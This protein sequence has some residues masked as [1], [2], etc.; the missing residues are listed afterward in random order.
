M[1]F[2]TC[3]PLEVASR[4]TLCQLPLWR[5]VEAQ[6]VV[7]TRTLVDTQQEQELLE[8]LLERDKPRVPAAAA[9]LDYLLS[10]PF[11]YPP[12]REGSRF[13]GYTDAGVWYGAERVR[14]ACA[15]LGY[16]RWRFVTASAGLRRLDAVPH[17]VFQAMVYA[18]SVDLRVQ[19]FRSDQPFWSDPVDYSVCQAFAQVART[20]QVQLIR[21]RS[22]RDPQHGGAGAVLD[23]AAFVGSVGVSRRQTWF[24]SVDRER[25]EWVRVGSQ[26]GAPQAYEFTFDADGKPRPVPLR[27]GPPR[28]AP[29]R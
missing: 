5:A 19:P 1:S 20:A 25:V 13:R 23:P 6:H 28:A 15:E 3:T 9:G 11:R 22:V 16:W 12:P 27:P 4:T 29:H 14:T 17:T 2:I 21:Y 8:A 18:S 10:K 24:L 26:P 7:A